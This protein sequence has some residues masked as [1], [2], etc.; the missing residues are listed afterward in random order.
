MGAKLPVLGVRVMS[1]GTCRTSPD[2]TIC[3]KEEKGGGRGG[4]WWGGGRRG[5]A[6]AE[7]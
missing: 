6:D 5:R 4:G 3:G 7:G 2:W 1:V